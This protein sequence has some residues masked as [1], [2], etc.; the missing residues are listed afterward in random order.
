MTGE[1]LSLVTVNGTQYS[2]YLD[3]ASSMCHLWSK[4][5]QIAGNDR[6]YSVT[7]VNTVLCKLTTCNISIL[8][9][10]VCPSQAEL[11]CE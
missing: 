3:I 10:G 2:L 6:T 4:L 1:K 11:H 8:F 9:A 7:V 5:S